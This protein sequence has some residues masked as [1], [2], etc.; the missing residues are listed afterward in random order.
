MRPAVPRWS[1]NALG[2]QMS[3]SD[4][5]RTALRTARSA[6]APHQDKTP[7]TGNAPR[8][9]IE[10]S[11]YWL[12][13]TGDLAMFEVTVGRLRRLLPHARIGV[14]TDTA[15]LL[16]A[17]FPDA[18]AITYGG[19]GAWSGPGRAGRLAARLGPRVVG[20]PALAWLRT[21]VWLPQQIRVLPRRARKLVALSRGQVSWAE[22][23]A[24][25]A[26]DGQQPETEAPTRD[27]T[28][29]PNV[30]AA[31]DGA[32]LVLALGGGY[33]TDMDFYQ[34]HRVLNLLEYAHE[35]GLPTALTGQGLGP[36]DAESLTRRVGEVL[37]AVD[38]ISLRE[39]RRGPAILERAGVPADRVMVT[40]DDAIELSF[41]V[42][43]PAL[44]GA[45]GI[46]VR[47]AGYSAV[48]NATLAAIRRAL[49]GVAREHRAPLA[50]LFIAE[51]RSQDRR[52]TLPLVRG[53]ESVIAPPPRYARPHDV[54]ARVSQCRVLV[55][56]AYHLAVFALAQ[57][58][59]V[60]ALTSSRYYDHKFD[61][62]ADMFGTGLESV[63]L[64]PENLESRLD[65][66]IRSAWDQAPRS[67]RPL[68]ASAASQIAASQQALKRIAQLVEDGRLA[69]RAQP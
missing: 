11:E 68:L 47:V 35:R 53:Y 40:G 67:R 65:T 15:P 28:L 23:R 13:N 54:A 17:Y 50:P 34:S 33:L 2:A 48:P 56:G 36:I 59:P 60:V 25:T 19:S 5:I 32:D 64:E 8:I 39:S 44:G 9:L 51:F 31:V 43:S 10:S 38:F 41:D 62:L 6:P 1:G 55:T 58:I 21:R 20:P 66:A 7:H 12:R 29:S 37:P 3:A 14:L 69:D 63:S 18:E 16:H 57:G 52:S 27:R 46:C 42:Q 30:A 49:H 26:V 61:G 24:R 22:L 4:S 45:I